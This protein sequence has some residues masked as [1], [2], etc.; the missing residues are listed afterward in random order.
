MKRLCCLLIVASALLAIAPA[1]KADLIFSATLVGSSETPPNGSTATGSALVTLLSANTNL[2][3]HETF[4]GL[5]GGNASGAH[6]HCCALPGVAVAI[7]IPFPIPP[8]P[9]ATSGVFDQTFDLG[10]LSTYSAAFIAANGGTLPLVEN[11]FITGLEAG[12][13]Y[14][15]IHNTM[16]PGG[17]IRGQLLAVPEPASLV[18]LGSALLGFGVLRRRKKQA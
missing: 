11:A 1:A 3:V 13:A 8:F 5:I 12:L 17:E 6:I 10:S 7:A 4:S 14:V 9:A 18:L 15:N 16:F 2:V